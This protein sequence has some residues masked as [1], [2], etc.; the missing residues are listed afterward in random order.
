MAIPADRHPRG[1]GVKHRRSTAGYGF[2]PLLLLI[3]IVIPYWQIFQKAGYS[4]W[5]SLVMLVPIVNLFVMWWFAFPTGRY[6]SAFRGGRWPSER[7]HV[8]RNRTRGLQAARFRARLKKRSREEYGV[9]EV[10]TRRIV[11]RGDNGP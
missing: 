8:H 5:L 2:I 7:R 10:S 9:N 11:A 3:L 4:R 6:L 1:T